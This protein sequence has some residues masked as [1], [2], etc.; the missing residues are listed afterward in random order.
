[1]EPSP[2][3]SFRPEVTPVL[4]HIVMRAIAKELEQRYQTWEEFSLDLANAHRAEAPLS[5]GEFSDSDKFETLRGLEFFAHFSDAELW[6]VARISAWRSA[7]SGEAILREGETGD[8]FCILA[9]GEVKVTKRGKLLNILN[10]GECFGEMAYLSKAERTRGA[11][12]TVLSNARIISVPT[13]KLAR[14]SEACRHKFD[15]AFLE[16]LVERLTMA[17]VR[18]SGV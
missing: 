4:D 10:A 7:A 17:N 11:D 1:V 6:E 14:A 3:S 18:L 16:I 2:P 15:R 5:A 12:V 9:A 8:F 13:E